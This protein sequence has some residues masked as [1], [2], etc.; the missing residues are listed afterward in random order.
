[1]SEKALSGV[2]KGRGDML[3]LD[4]SSTVPAAL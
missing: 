1:M 3:P 2:A 4:C